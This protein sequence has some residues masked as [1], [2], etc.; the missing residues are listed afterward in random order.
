MAEEYPEKLEELKAM[1]VLEA[2]KY[3]VFPL[4]DRGTDRLTIPKPSPLAGKTSFTF[5][6]GALRLPETA[7]PNT[8]NTSWTMEAILHT[9]P[10][11][12][13]G[14]VN[15]I[16]G[17]GSGYSLFVKDAYPVFLYNY[18]EEITVI[19]SSKKLPDGLAS[20][21]VNLTMTGGEWAKALPWNSI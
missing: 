1:W 21:R 10:N 14:V 16:G 12:K 6:E 3:H 19:K 18:F 4:D 15:A 20:V 13:D 8:K 9:G 5:Y 11:T 2:E 7:A 17:L